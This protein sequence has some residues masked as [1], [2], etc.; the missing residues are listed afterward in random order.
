MSLPPPP[1]PPPPPSSYDAGS[2][3]DISVGAAAGVLLHLRHRRV[4]IIGRGGGDASNI[5]LHVSSL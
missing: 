1:P 5:N 2:L 4:V 3:Y